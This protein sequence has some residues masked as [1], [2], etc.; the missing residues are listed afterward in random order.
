MDSI[1]FNTRKEYKFFKNL[2]FDDDIP[3]IW[4]GGRKCNFKGCERKDLQP[5]IV[6]GWFWASTNMRIPNKRRCRFCDWSRTGGL[7]KPQPDNREMGESGT[8]E[9]CIA[10]L[11]DFYSDGI[12]WHDVACRHRK[13]IICQDSKPLLD[14][15]NI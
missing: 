7:N 12:R 6:N 13:P 11:N 4:T 14:S 5:A 3:Y 2:I 1:T 8:D 15:L 10:V 9:A